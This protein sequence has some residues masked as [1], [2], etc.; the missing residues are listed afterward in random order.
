[1]TSA[2]QI[3]EEM[4]EGGKFVTAV[5]SFETY[6]RIND[7]I[8]EQIDITVRVKSC[9]YDKDETHCLLLKALT[10]AKRKVR[11]REFKLNNP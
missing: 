1:M 11:D 7:E 6:L 4:V 10:K 2:K 9:K 8:A 3:I 5:M